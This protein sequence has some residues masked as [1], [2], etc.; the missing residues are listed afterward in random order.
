MNKLFILRTAEHVMGLD[1]FVRKNWRAMADAGKPLAV[2]VTEHKAKRNKDQNARY[3]AGVLPA[4]AQQ[5]WVRGRQYSEEVWHDFFKRRFIGME[6]LPSG[7]I[8]GKSSANLNV[9]DFADFSDEVEAYGATE[10]GV[11]YPAYMPGL[12]KPPRIEAL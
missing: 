1:I 5:A 4:I 3:W 6:E 12:S 7:E 9:S 2:S 11:I 10:L 8:T